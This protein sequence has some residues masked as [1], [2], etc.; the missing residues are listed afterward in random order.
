MIDAIDIVSAVQWVPDQT[1]EV[2]DIFAYN[3]ELLG[4]SAQN[5]V[6]LCCSGCHF[7]DGSDRSGCEQMAEL[8][9]CFKKIF[10]KIE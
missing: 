3:M 6:G 7:Y 5:R 4:V 10:I 2:G 1:L 9:D 8:P